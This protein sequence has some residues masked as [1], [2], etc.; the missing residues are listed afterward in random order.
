MAYK[1]RSGQGGPPR[2]SIACPACRGTGLDRAHALTYA[3][4]RAPHDD[5][6]RASAIRCAPCD[7]SGRLTIE[8]ALALGFPI[9]SP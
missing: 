2:P 9:A 7:G 1:I 3:S 6:A 5:A 8:R 4:G